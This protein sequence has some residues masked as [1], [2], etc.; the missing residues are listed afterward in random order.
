MEK[1]HHIQLLP[2][3]VG[4]TVFLPGDISRAKVIADHFDSAELIAQNRQYNTFTGMYKGIKVSVTSTGIGGAAAAIA[5]EELI[6][7]GA[8]NF[9]RIGTGGAFQTWLPKPCILVITGAVRGDGTTREYFP[10]EYPAVADFY[11]VEGMITSAAELN[12]EVHPGLEWS[13]DAFYAGS[14]LSNLDILTIEKPWIDA[15]VLIA[16]QEASTVLSLSMARKCRG[17]TILCSS[18]CHQ[19]PEMNATPEQMEKAISNATKISLETAVKLHKLDHG[20]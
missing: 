18:G 16:S 5:I 4:E 19:H 12:I 13:H 17:G 6:K 1:Q 15:G 20:L 2:G 11:I 7:V 9:I 8:K 10:V 14:P 3:D